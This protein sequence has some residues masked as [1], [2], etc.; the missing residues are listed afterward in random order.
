MLSQLLSVVKPNAQ[1]RLSAVRDVDQVDSALS[2]TE[3]WRITDGQRRPKGIE[4]WKKF[5]LHNLAN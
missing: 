1:L 4:L 2:R 5:R 3:S